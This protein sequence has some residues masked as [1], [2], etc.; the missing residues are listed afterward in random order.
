M[1]LKDYYGASARAG[2][3]SHYPWKFRVPTRGHG[4]DPT[5]EATCYVSS[6]RG[7]TKDPSLNASKNILSGSFLLVAFV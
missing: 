6:R 3:L 1:S 2:V 5:K 7:G 4:G